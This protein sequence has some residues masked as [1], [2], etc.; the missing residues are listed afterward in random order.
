VTQNSSKKSFAALVGATLLLASSLASASPV[1]VSAYDNSIAGGVGQVSGVTLTTGQHFAVMAAANDTWNYGYGWAQYETN[2]DGVTGAFMN[3]GNP[4]GSFLQSQ[5]GAL[6][7]QIGTGNFFTVGTAFDGVANASGMLKF[8]FVDSDQY[9]N[10]GT[11][12]ANVNATALPEPASMLL[13]GV[14]L[15]ALGLARRRKA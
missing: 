12:T 14:A 13:A 10:V 11:V 2:A 9:N 8:F 4:D 1:I 6:I 3:I 5:I 15:G 7:G